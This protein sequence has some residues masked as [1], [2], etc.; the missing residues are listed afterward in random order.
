LANRG[1]STIQDLLLR[2]SHIPG[3]IVDRH[4]QSR[5]FRRCRSEDHSRRARKP[6]IWRAFLQ[7]SQSGAIQMARSPI[8]HHFYPSTLLTQK[9]Q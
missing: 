3:S 9:S 5:P 2:I 4:E 1:G 6:V 8:G 7:I